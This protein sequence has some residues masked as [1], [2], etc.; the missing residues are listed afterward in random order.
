MNKKTIKLLMAVA[1]TVMTA[2][3]AF[4]E[5]YQAIDAQSLTCI[6]KLVQT[7][8]PYHRLDVDRFEGMTSGEQGQGKMSAGLAFAFSTNSTVVGV[9]VNLASIG[10]DAASPS[11]CTR[12]FDLYTRIKG[13]WV[14]AGTRSADKQADTDQELI[15]ATGLSDSPMEYILYC[16][17]YCEINSL[18]VLTSKGSDI[19]AIPNP[20]RGRV[21]VWGSSFTHGS[22]SQRTGMSYCAQLARMTGINFINMGFAGNCKL[23]QYFADALLEADVDAYVF[24]AF[25]NPSKDQIRE[26]LFPFIERFQKE[27]PGVPLIF[28]QTIY[29][30]HR[31]A[32]PAY[33]AKEQARM[34]LA[35]SLMKIAVKKY[36]NV[37]WVPNTNATGK[38]HETTSDGTHPGDHGYTLWAESVKGPILKILKRYGIK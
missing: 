32:K 13:E 26:R 36:K 25:S 19:K 16:P 34:D 33:D 9:K 5:D 1:L 12:G 18:A 27:K 24:D 6:N 2:I 35:D 3:P 21:A 11:N 29:R 37:Y 22:G 7:Q 15:I 4:A 20:Y 14:W 30:E 17:M 23:Q 28:T 38:Y 31:I 8:N 10:S